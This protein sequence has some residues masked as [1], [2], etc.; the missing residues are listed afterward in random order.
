MRVPIPADDPRTEERIRAH[1]EV[2][3]SL[4]QRLREAD[5]AERRSLYNTVYADLYRLVPDHPLVRVAASSSNERDGQI[6]KLLRWIAPY[7]GPDRTFLEV[8]PG[9]CRFA[10]AVAARARHAY[11]VDVTDGIV[12]RAKMP[13]NFTLAIS[14]GTSIPVPSE[15]VDAAFSDQLMEHL[16][17]EDAL[18]QLREIRRALKP[19]GVYLVL[20]PNRLT[21]PHDVSQFFSPTAEGM[22]LREYS[23]GDLAALLREL[24]FRRVQTALPLRG[25]L[26]TLPT[27][28]FVVLERALE[29]LPARWRAALARK[30]LV[31]GLLGVRVLATR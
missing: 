2:E 10:F 6:A 15:T 8:G 5:K 28:P 7:V 29:L 18:D 17:P 23:N 11:A 14:D 25:R 27:L 22:H 30:R 3:R 9:D 19:G 16:H 13:A 24:G 31:R 21:G 26:V 12:D 20:T 4:A 1:Y